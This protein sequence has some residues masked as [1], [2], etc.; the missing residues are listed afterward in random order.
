MLFALSI[1][2]NSDRKLFLPLD[3]KLSVLFFLVIPGF[4]IGNIFRGFYASRLL[5]GCLFE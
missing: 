1:V 3:L 2:K 4:S 5:K